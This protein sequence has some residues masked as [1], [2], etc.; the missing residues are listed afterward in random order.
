MPNDQSRD[1]R[2]LQYEQRKGGVLSGFDF[3]DELSMICN[4][5]LRGG[6]PRTRI[7]GSTANTTHQLPHLAVPLVSVQ[8]TV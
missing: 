5:Q 8:S 4:I 3:N 1:F 7:N 2:R 6:V